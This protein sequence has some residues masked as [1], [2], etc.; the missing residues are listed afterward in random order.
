MVAYIPLVY[1]F[2]L[3][4]Q[5]NFV[6]KPRHDTGAGVAN[7]S[8]ASAYYCLQVPVDTEVWRTSSR[9]MHTPGVNLLLYLQVEREK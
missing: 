4:T 1:I 7:S 5:T 3:V 6:V 2:I 8:L 9:P